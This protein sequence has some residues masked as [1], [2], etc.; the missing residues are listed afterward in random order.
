MQNIATR[1]IVVLSKGATNM[2]KKTESTYPFGEFL[3]WAREQKGVS[4][5]E[6]EKATGIPNAYLSQ[7]ETGARKKLPPPDRM[8]IIAHYYNVNMEQLL[9][10][11]G[12]Y[13]KDEVPETYDQKIEKLFLYV[14][15]DPK[16]NTGSRINP[17]ELS[18]E[19][20]RFIIELH[21]HHITKDPKIK[22]MLKAK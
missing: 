17:K 16:F 18:I 2:A 12:Y 6:T 22:E 3:K 8:R 9:E 7:L 13:N 15:N 10:K 1:D 20:K 14:I 4:L 5:K 19:A 11:A 21:T